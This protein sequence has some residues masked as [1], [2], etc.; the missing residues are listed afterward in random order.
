LIIS[1]LGLFRPKFRHH[2]LIATGGALVTWIM[3]WSMRVQLPL[4]QS[5]GGG[6]ISILQLSPF[7]LRVDEITWPFALAVV[8]LFLA[9][10]LT[11][12]GRAAETSWVV[13]AGDLGMTAL[14]LMAV[15]AENPLTLLIGWFLVDLIELGILLRQVERE[16]TRRRVVLFFSTNLL[17]LMSVFGAVIASGSMG[18]K[19]SFS[20]I[21]SQAQLFL[22]LGAG[23]RMGVFPLQVVF[24][25]QVHH[26]RGQGTL[27]RLLPPATSLPLLVYAAYTPVSQ[28]WRYLLLTF[29]VLAALYGGVAWARARDELQGRTFWIIGMAGLAFIGT[30][31]FSPTAALT[32]GLAMLYGGAV[33]FLAS[34]R[35]RWMISLGILGL[36]TLMALPFTPTYLGLGMYQPLNVFVILTPFAHLALLFGYLRHSRRQ[37]DPLV[38]VERWVHVIYPLG[39]ILLPVTY[40]LSAV[41]SPE[42]PGTTAP[43]LWPIILSVG[44][45]VVGGILY[46]KKIAL[47]TRVFDLLDSVFSLR[48]LYPVLAWLYQFAGRVAR[49]VS[50]LLEGEGG[51]LWALVVLVL[52]VSILTQI[53]VGSGAV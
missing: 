13:W 48:W 53:A 45:A 46:W 32:W 33:L 52:L 49:E 11:D 21:P 35:T 10:M 44:I 26:Q 38:G 12:V 3:I 41:F 28:T 50:L 8:T 37:T 5:L 1:L 4:V 7:S 30:L 24:L 47:P 31:Q 18:L 42:V 40:I 22:V 20:T 39:L 15:L 34:V 17:G 27:L 19:L 16:D 51:V 23:L 2:W 25:R 43:P 6:Q 36:V 14:G 9:V 29:A